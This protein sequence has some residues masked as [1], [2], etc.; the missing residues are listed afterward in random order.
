MAEEPQHMTEAGVVAALA[1]KSTARVSIKSIGK[2]ALDEDEVS[3]AVVPNGFEIRSLKGLID[4]WLPRPR[5]KEGIAV[6]QTLDS[7]SSHVTRHRTD[8]SAIF[9]DRFGEKPKLLCIFDY[10]PKFPAKDGSPT[11]G[12]ADWCRHKARYD[13]PLSDEWGAWVARSGK[14]FGQEE[15]AEFIEQR[16]YDLM[17]TGKASDDIREYAELLGMSL[18]SPSRMV[19]LSRGLSVHVGKR[20]QNHANLG[21]GEATISY[22]TEHS[23]P[24]GA[25]LKIPGAFLVAIPVFRAGERFQILVRLRYRVR[26]GVVSWLYELTRAQ[27]V[28]DTAFD[29][30][31]E[32]AAEDTEL[33]LF[34][35]SPE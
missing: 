9:A 32:K 8:N 17:D 28:F 18:A 6:L 16:V 2:A 27:D 3:I 12:K 34:V 26:G 29:E 20:V 24:D 33:P 7:F 5:R 1:K 15:F 10:H 23:G 21:S 31:C 22:V 25:P 14:E 30:A 35:G 11:D 19:E 13:F 4:E